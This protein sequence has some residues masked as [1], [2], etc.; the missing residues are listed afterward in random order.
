MIDYFHIQSFYKSINEWQPLPILTIPK[1]N[2][3]V[4]F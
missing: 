4:Y 3:Y 1:F 2:N